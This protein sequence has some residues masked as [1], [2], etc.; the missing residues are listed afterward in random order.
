MLAA[1]ARLQ[2]KWDGQHEFEPGSL[3]RLRR[4][5]VHLPAPKEMIDYIPKLHYYFQV[6]ID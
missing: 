4:E 1:L 6:A 5:S 2:M 3:V